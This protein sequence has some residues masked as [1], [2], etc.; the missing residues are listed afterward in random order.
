MLEDLCNPFTALEEIRRVAKRGFIETPHR[1]LE[2]CFTLSNHLGLF[3]GWGHHRWMF[4]TVGKNTIKVIPKFWQMMRHDA[5]QVVNWTGPQEFAFFWEESYEFFNTAVVDREGY[6]WDRLGDDHNEFV[7][8]NREF[9]VTAD[10]HVSASAAASEMPACSLP[11]A[12]EVASPGAP[13]S[14]TTAKA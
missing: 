14:M 1:G 10:E 9:I 6:G 12:P 3:P 8:R 7:K 2:S 11:R 5:E 13:T 4:E